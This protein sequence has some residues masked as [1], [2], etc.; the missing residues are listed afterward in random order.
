[1]LPANWHVLGGYSSN[2]TPSPGK[3]HGMRGTTGAATT[4]L[5]EC[6]GK[7]PCTRVRMR[8]DVTSARTAPINPPDRQAARTCATKSHPVPSPLERLGWG[9]EGDCEAGRAYSYSTSRKAIRAI[10]SITRL[11]AAA[12]GQSL[13]R[14]PPPGPRTHVRRPHRLP[15]HLG[16][17]PGSTAPEGASQHWP[18][19]HR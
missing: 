9:G 19:M 2:L 18:H 14:P 15:L 6:R 7:R 11:E 4:S 1:M 13:N 8:R 5:V 16:A 17:G 10:R 12:A 3:Q